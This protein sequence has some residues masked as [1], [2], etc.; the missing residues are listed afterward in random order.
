MQLLFCQVCLD[1][2]SLYLNILD[3]WN[4]GFPL[5]TVHM[6]FIPASTHLTGFNSHSSPIDP[7]NGQHKM[8]MKMDIKNEV[9]SNFKI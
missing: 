7:S 2:S 9:C 3:Y 5:P 4:A 1:Q 6:P 8:S